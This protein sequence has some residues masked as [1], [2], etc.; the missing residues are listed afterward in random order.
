MQTSL[1]SSNL[2]NSVNA[3]RQNGCQLEIT[4]VVEARFVQLQNYNNKNSEKEHNIDCH[5][6]LAHKHKGSSIKDVAKYSKKN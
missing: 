5:E 4:S 1:H 3:L 6:A 2:N